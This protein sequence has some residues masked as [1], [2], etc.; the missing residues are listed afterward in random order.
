MF[1][2]TVDVVVIGARCAGAATAMLLARAGRTVLLVDRGEY[3]TD[4]LSTHALM[5][6]GVRQ[7]SRWNLLDRIIDAGTPPVKMTTFHVGSQAMRVE[8]KPKF[9]VEAL[10]APRRTVLDRVLV[11]AARESGAIVRFGT[12]LTA[13]SRASDGRVAGVVLRDPAGRT[14]HVSTQYVVGADG[15]RSTVAGLVG[16]AVYRAG[17]HATSVLYGYWPDLPVDGFNWH[18]AEASAAGVIPT[19][20]GETLVFAGVPA[21]RWP[22]TVAAGRFDAFV[23]ILRETAPA[24]AAAILSTGERPLTGFAG[25][26]GYFRQ[27]WGPGWAL[28]GDAGYFKD[29]LTAHGI[30]DAF[31]DAE[32]LA[33]AIVDGSPMA[34]ADYQR[35]RDEW[36]SGLFEITDRIASFEWTLDSVGALLER[37]SREMADDV[38]RMVQRSAAIAT[39]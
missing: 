39:A 32:L 28:V 14:V 31:R 16:A 36:S 12:R 27:S 26:A 17:E 19:N 37:L 3:G 25:R 33:D 15:M 30:T 38:K 35:C 18:Y 4:I 20:D 7:L 22:E 34:L 11:D 10:F 24:V 5:R 1:P 2:E 13:L 6:G 8:I 29:P 21:A 23:R 9:G